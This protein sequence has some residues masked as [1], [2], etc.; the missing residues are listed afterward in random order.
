MAVVRWSGA[1]TSLPPS[2][3]NLYH[4]EHPPKLIHKWTSTGAG[5]RTST[6][7]Q[8]S[9]TITTSIGDRPNLPQTRPPV[10]AGS[11]PH[12]AEQPCEVGQIVRVDERLGP[13][14]CDDAWHD[15]VVCG[16]TRVE[17]GDFGRLALSRLSLCPLGVCSAV[18]KCRSQPP[19][20]L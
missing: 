7:P 18:S 1:Y 10:V 14:P 2:S 16:R 15:R 17:P 6:S 19:P 5:S 8:T 13:R 3:F 9:L 12:I 11:L 4:S 20:T